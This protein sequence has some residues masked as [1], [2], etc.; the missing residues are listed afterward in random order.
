VREEHFKALQSPVQPAAMELLDSMAGSYAIESRC[1]FWEQNLVEI[2]L[3]FPAEQKMRHGFNRYVMRNAMDGLLPPKVQWRPDKTDFSAQ[4]LD[5]IRVAER[6]HIDQLLE[7]WD[8]SS[9]SVSQ[10][11]ELEEVRLLW[12]QVQDAPF[13]SPM[14]MQNASVLWKVLNLGLWLSNDMRN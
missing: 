8:T 7:L 14:A 13:G 10:Y 1:P 11:V 9:E 2:C 6:Q 5:S 4:I 3:A 12:L